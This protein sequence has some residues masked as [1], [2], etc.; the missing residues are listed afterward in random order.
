[1]MRACRYD[2]QSPSGVI[3]VND[4]EKPKLKS[5]HALIKVHAAGVN[6]VDAKF[7]IGDKL[8]ESWMGWASRT[9]AGHTPGFDFSGVIEDVAASSSA[10]GFA[11]GDA[12]YGFACNPAHFVLRPFSR[13]RGSFAEYVIAPL[14][15]IAKKPSSLPHAEAAALPLVGTTAIQAFRQ[16]HLRPDQRLL[17]IGA[18]GG[19]GHVAVQIATRIGAHVTAVC[20][21]RNAEFVEECGAS[22]VLT[23]DTGDVFE[24]IAADAVQHGAYDLCID[25]VS[26]ADARDQDA[27]YAVRIRSMKPRVL[28]TG[29]GTDSHNYIVFGGA[30]GSWAVALMKRFLKINC[31]GQ[32][33]LFWIKMPHSRGVLEDLATFADAPAN[34]DGGRRP[35]R[36]KVAQQLPLSEAAAR[37][38]FDALRARRTVGKIV[39]NVVR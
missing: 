39:L 37:E 18:S 28:A 32:M 20:S 25:C 6:P 4:V 2:A 33:E 19:L 23:Y 22:V 17:I 5:G 27:S 11:A 36:P 38:A 8:P 3:L 7:I 21:S 26:S 31:F 16:H 12:V 24:K 10:M 1:M 9:A 29:P 13:L 15:Q 14:D 30:T 34:P 35:L